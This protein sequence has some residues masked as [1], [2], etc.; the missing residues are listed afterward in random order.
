MS[1]NCCHKDKG[2]KAVELHVGADDTTIP[3]EGLYQIRIINQGE[4]GL[5]IGTVQ[6]DP[7]TCMSFGL[8]WLPC[9][10]T[11][12]CQ[13]NESETGQKKVT[14][15]AVKIIEYCCEK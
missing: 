10:T 3:V 15:S 6:V 11:L 2:W 4:V 8:D 5:K 13:W 12:D 7:G 1:L 9:A 14:I